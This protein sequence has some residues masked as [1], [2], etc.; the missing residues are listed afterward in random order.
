MC[1]SRN[2][3]HHIIWT[4]ACPTCGSAVGQPCTWTG[5][6]ELQHGDR[7]AVHSERKAAWQQA[8]NPKVEL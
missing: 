7:L 1:A 3:E 4:T 2:R 5:R 8:G 6:L